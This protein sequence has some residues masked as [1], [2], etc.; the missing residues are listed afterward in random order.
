MANPWIR[1][2]VRYE[3]NVFHAPWTTLSQFDSMNPIIILE[4]AC[5]IREEKH[6]NLAIQYICIVS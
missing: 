2:K 5:A 3:K 6:K 4:Y 1:V